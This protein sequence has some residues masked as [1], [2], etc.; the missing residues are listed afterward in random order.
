MPSAGRLGVSSLHG[1]G[2][3]YRYLPGSDEPL[4]KE[5]EDQFR[6]LEPVESY[7]IPW[8]ADFISKNLPPACELVCPLG[9]GSHRDHVLTRKAGERLGL[10]VWH[11]ADYP[12][13]VRGEHAL[14]DWIPPSAVRFSLEISPAGLK[15]WQ[16]GFACQRSQIPLLFVDQDDMHAS[17]ERYLMAGHGF[18]LWKF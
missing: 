18:T 15:A 10:P 12:Y 9:I 1:S 6:P 3:L 11:Y 13:L 5:N 7:L 4:I 17:I 2:Q 14:A 8:V 16:E